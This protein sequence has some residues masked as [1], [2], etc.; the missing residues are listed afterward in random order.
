MNISL[1]KTLNKTN[2]IDP[3]DLETGKVYQFGHFL[4]SET[5]SACIIVIDSSDN[6]V[7]TFNNAFE[8]GEWLEDNDHHVKGELTPYSFSITIK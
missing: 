6:D 3:G 8:F 1:P 2:L 7:F 4:A 5:S